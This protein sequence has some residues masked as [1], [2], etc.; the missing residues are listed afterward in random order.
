MSDK[1]EYKWIPKNG[2][3]FNAV[4]R[5]RKHFQKPNYPM[6][7]AWFNTENR[8]FYTE[9]IEKPF[10]EIEASE[11]S[12]GVL[13]EISS[14]TSCFGHREEWDEW[15]KYLL[16]NLILRSQEFYFFN[17]LL[18]QSVITAFM[19][20][21]WKGIPEEYDGFRKD[22]IDSL[23]VCL[24]SKE[25]WFDYLDE[26]TQTTH[27]R[28][29]FLDTYRDGKDNLRLDWNSR[30]SNE[31]LS[32]LMFFCL[33]YLN[34]EEII[35]WTNSL[36]SIKDIYWRGALMVWLL[37]AYDILEEP[38]VVPS[39]IEKANPEINWENS[40]VLGSRYGSID[41]EHPPADEYNDNRDFFHAENTKL[42]LEQIRKQLTD[43]L[44]LDWA[45]SF[46]QDKFVAESTYNVPELLM[47]KL[48]KNK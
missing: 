4:E 6:G 13:F 43:E 40:H 20:I 11:L 33:K 17:E 28:V 10:E 38:I 44:I 2:V 22:V 25:L 1:S 7:E 48:S 34:S 24:M 18:A 21:Y 26:K 47:E 15:F 27:L 42:F 12:T 30:S 35:S 29:F 14:G 23:S 41:A 37:G 3:S 32:A 36:F 5:M 45:E 9:L 39:M 8:R 46:A 31:S 19:T 16:P